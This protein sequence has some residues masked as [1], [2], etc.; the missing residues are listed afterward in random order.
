MK[1]LRKITYRSYQKSY[2]DYIYPELRITG[3]FLTKKYGL[4][5]GDYIKVQYLKD[6]IV[7]RKEKNEKTT[8]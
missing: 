1:S 8:H 3:D 4:K 7:I 6:K 2:G 5:I